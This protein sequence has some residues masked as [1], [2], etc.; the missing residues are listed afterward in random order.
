MN[1]ITT[2]IINH[3]TSPFPG[4]LDEKEMLAKGKRTDPS[5]ARV[6]ST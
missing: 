6:L 2:I 3:P 5:A 4:G 1:L